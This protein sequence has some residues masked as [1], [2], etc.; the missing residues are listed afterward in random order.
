VSEDEI[1]RD[2]NGSPLKFQKGDHVRITGR[3]ALY[4]AGFV[5]AY[6]EDADGVIAYNFGRDNVHNHMVPEGDL[7]L[8]PTHRIQYSA[9]GFT[10][11]GNYVN[12]PMWGDIMDIRSDGHETIEGAKER[13]P[14][15]FGQDDQVAFVVISESLQSW[16][17]GGWRL[18][19]TV[20]RID[21]P[22]A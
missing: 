5:Y 3:Y 14:D 20:A 10:K 1:W 21:R 9:V 12:V 2:R 13:V 15:L 22:A 11:D 16:S 6:S 18:G 7:E 17:G 4:P 19:R 8:S